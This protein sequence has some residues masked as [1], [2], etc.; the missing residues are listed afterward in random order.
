MGAAARIGIVSADEEVARALS[1]H[2]A[3]SRSRVVWTAEKLATDL[4]GTAAVDVLLVDANLWEQQKPRTALDAHV[5][6][7]A[8]YADTDELFKATPAGAVGYFLKRTLPSHLLDPAFGESH[9]RL[10]GPLNTRVRE[11]FS[12]LLSAVPSTPERE[13]VRLTP[14]EQQIVEFLSRGY[15]D[16]EIAD[17]LQISAWTVHNHLK[18]IFEKLGVHSRTEAAIKHLQK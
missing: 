13:V 3:D 10:E 1:R 17:K 7:F 6:P 12:L 4:V 14:R 16:K 11:Y 15:S 18:H 8:V 2:F 5:V 9:R